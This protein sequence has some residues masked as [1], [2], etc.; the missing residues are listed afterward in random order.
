MMGKSMPTQTGEMAPQQIYNLVAEGTKLKIVKTGGS[1]S[2]GITLPKDELR[3]RDLG[4]GDEV[5]I[6]PGDDPDTFELH[7]PPQDG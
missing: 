5:V 7:L 6:L 2:L 3:Q 1:G 4:A